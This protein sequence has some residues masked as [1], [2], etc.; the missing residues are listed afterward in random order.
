MKNLFNNIPQEEKQ[1]ILEMHRGA[2]M[3]F[4]E[5]TVPAK[6]ATPQPTA[7][8]KVGGYEIFDGTK[9][10]DPVINPEAGNIKAQL[11]IKL[12]VPEDD[13]T[14]RT[15]IWKYRQ[16]PGGDKIDLPSKKGATIEFITKTPTTT[17]Q[18]TAS[19]SIAYNSKPM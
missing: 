1:R 8:I 13:D 18:Q 14:L 16:Q 17:P 12:G 2:K 10:V 7:A 15:E 3:V 19:S 6:P 5:Q 11:K 9:F 4:G